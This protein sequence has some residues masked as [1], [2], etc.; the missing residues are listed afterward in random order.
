MPNGWGIV[1]GALDSY[2][3]DK[4]EV[5]RGANGLLTG[6]GNAS[7]TINYVRKR[8]TNEAQGEVGISYGS[9]GSTREQIDYSTPFTATGTWAGRVVAA[10]EDDG[11]YLRGLD[12][13]RDYFYGVVDGQVGERGTL[14]F[15]YSY[16]KAKTNGNMWGALTFNDSDGNQLEWNRN[17]STA[18]DWTF[19][20]T[21]NNNA[22]V[23]YSYA[24]SSDWQVKATYN[25]QRLEE[26]DLLFFAYASH[27]L[28][29]QTHAGLTGWAYRGEDTTTQHL[30]NVSV[31]GRFDWL[32]QRFLQSRHEWLHRQ[33]GPGDLPFGVAREIRPHHHGRH[34][35]LRL[36]RCR[37]AAHGHGCV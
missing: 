24:L 21:Q 22:F 31:N 37:C 20:N 1:T 27:G 17:A 16:Q 34:H 9:W 2:G 30:G 19:W 25:Y 26:D 33:H 4:I 15:G 3:Y 23:E 35:W 5:I 28:D 29:P 13:K 7:G 10:H 36:G 6:V 12:N 8:P 18:Q 32:G 11:S 14:T